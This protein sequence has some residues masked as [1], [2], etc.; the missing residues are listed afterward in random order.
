MVVEA[1]GYRTAL[2]L[3]ELKREAERNDAVTKDEGRAGI[4]NDLPSRVSPFVP[5]TAARRNITMRK[6][7]DRLHDDLPPRTPDDVTKRRS[8]R[9]ERDVHYENEMRFQGASA[10]SFSRRHGEEIYQD[11]EG[12][13]LI[14][15][16]GKERG[17]FKHAADRRAPEKEPFH[18]SMNDFLQE[19]EARVFESFMHDSA[20][21]ND[22]FEG[23]G[24][25]PDPRDKLPG[26]S[27][28]DD[29]H[30]GSDSSEDVEPNDNGELSPLDG[31]ATPLFLRRDIPLLEEDG[32]THSA[33]MILWTERQQ[34]SLQLVQALDQ[35]DP[36]LFDEIEIK[37]RHIN[38]KM[39][40][41][42]DRY[43]K[44]NKKQYL[45]VDD[46]PL[47]AP[48]SLLRQA[49][50]SSNEGEFQI[51]LDYQ[52]NKIIRKANRMTATRVVYQWAQQYLR[53]A[54]SLEVPDLANLLLLHEN[55]VLPGLFGGCSCFWRGGNYDYIPGKITRDIREY[56][57]FATPP[58][59]GP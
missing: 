35:D 43:K 28:V 38:K 34:A 29:H 30:E 22:V 59:R 27:S 48:T 50:K 56:F 4:E 47:V 2:R 37:M 51:I 12:G 3:E 45:S 53:E 32:A 52:E 7:R 18:S 1:Q 42:L 58:C 24:K 15:P 11:I 5:N 57:G 10:V 33:L 49:F 54:F 16:D 23:F 46:L 40:D 9:R 19:D 41:V 14:L 36:T 55:K 39:H 13:S 31:G 25:S 44:G 26:A 17:L 20:E 21:K 8:T 6:S